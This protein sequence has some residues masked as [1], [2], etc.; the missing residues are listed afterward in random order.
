MKKDIKKIFIILSGGKGERF[1]KEQPKQLSMLAG[2]TILEHTITRI[3]GIKDIDKII[4]VSKADIINKT[5]KIV[6][7]VSDNRIQII[8]GGKTRLESSKKGVEI[9]QQYGKSKI[10]IHDV[11]RPF[12]ATSTID[13]CYKKLDEYDCIDVV[14][15]SAD[16]LITST[17][18]KT[19]ENVPDRSKMFRGQTPQGFNSETLHGI[20]KQIEDINSLKFSDDC[21]LFRAYCPDKPIGLVQGDERNIKITHPSDLFIAEQ[22]I[23]IGD[24]KQIEKHT[25][26]SA[27]FAGKTYIVFGGS[28]GIGKLLCQHLQNAKAT[29]YSYSRSNG[30]D[31]SDFMKIQNLFSELQ[32][33]KTK[34]DGIIVSSGILN[35]SPISNVS[36]E[37][38]QSLISTNYTGCANICRLAYPLLKETQGHLILISSSSYYKGRK[39]YSLYSSS[40]AAVANI[41]QA[42]SEEWA[43]DNIKVNCIAPRRTNT[44]MRRSAFPNEDA[45]TLL[46]PSKVSDEIVNVLASKLSGLII[47]VY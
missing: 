30:Y 20:Y 2:K 47:P 10:L 21:G 26:P 46:E 31:I 22:L 7:K 3:C 25:P 23:K 43:D 4:I 39:N 19:L 38:L 18:G 12:I 6:D 1:S 45:D 33:S 11:V 34:V 40:K 44:P 5:Q 13:E 28:S 17:D 29:V 32:S 9:A 37:E 15:P 14:I 27:S 35:I 36:L 42:L 24:D 16:T 41:T 8:E